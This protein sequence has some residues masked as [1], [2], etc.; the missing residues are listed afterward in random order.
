MNRLYILFLPFLL[1]S[2][3]TVFNSQYTTSHIVTNPKGA[4]I[5]INGIDTI[6]CSNNEIA[7]KRS[8]VP[9]RIEVLKDSLKQTVQVLPKTSLI[10][11][12]N[13][14]YYP[15]FIVDLLNDKRFTYPDKIYIDLYNPQN[16]YH[17]LRDDW[18]K[19]K[20][21]PINIGLSVPIINGYY[22]SSNHQNNSMSGVLGVAFHSEYY[23]DRKYY[24]SAELGGLEH[25]NWVGFRLYPYTETHR[26]LLYF[27][28]RINE[29][30]NRWN[31]GAGLSY[32]QFNMEN[33][34]HD[35]RN[36]GFLFPSHQDTVYQ[37]EKQYKEGIGLN[38]SVQYQLGKYFYLGTMFQPLLFNTPPAAKGYM[39]YINFSL[40]FKLP[41]W[42]R[43]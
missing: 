10:F 38:L 5:V 43:K 16:S 28:T 37:I 4:K 29:R 25:N 33:T 17:V 22:Y 8:S 9:V 7:I 20:D 6:C 2:C 27:N 41:V 18:K 34:L 35:G 39:H 13:A 14:L 23:L 12:L 24:L 30:V 1:G 3:A 26:R 32:Q 40:I 36:G 31:F 21:Q 11:F 42:S 19:H 15:A